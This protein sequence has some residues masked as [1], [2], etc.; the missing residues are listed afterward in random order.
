MILLK[1]KNAGRGFT[2]AEVMIVV[3]IVAILATVAVILIRPGDISYIEYNR[4]A[5]AIA[6]AVQNRLTDIRNTGDMSALRG[7]GVSAVASGTPSTGAGTSAEDAGGLRCVFSHKSVGTSIT[8]NG[9]MSYI[10]PFGA[11]EHKLT[12]SYY[13]VCYESDTGMVRFVLYSE[14]YF[15]D[16]TFASIEKYIGSFGEGDTAAVAAEAARKADNIG[17]YEG[18]VDSQ[19]V[20]FA[21]LPTPQLTVTNYEELTLNIFLPEVKQLKGKNIGFIVSL[22]DKNG[23]AYKGS[24]GKQKLTFADAAIYSTIDFGNG[25]V[26]PRYVKQKVTTGANYKMILDTVRSCTATDLSKSLTID[27]NGSPTPTDQLPKGIFEDWANR[28]KAFKK[29]F[30]LGENTNI[31]VTVYC[32]DDAGA[33]DPTF[34]PRSA[35]I[36][37]NGWFNDC[38]DDTHSDGRVTG[39]VDIACGRH[40]QNL[41]K[42]SVMRENLIKYLPTVEDSNDDGIFEYGKY[43]RGMADVYT[44][45]SS[46]AS[47]EVKYEDVTEKYVLRDDVFE[48]T[49]AQQ[50]NAIDFNTAGWKED[51]K[52]I[53]FT[54]INLPYGFYY[55]GNYLTISHLYVF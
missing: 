22:A 27:E 3:A 45:G 21:N 55:Y 19:E 38:K 42:I 10:L 44:D 53:P 8:S 20:A 12:Q 47:P 7:L 49:E 16:N 15:G 5:E 41:G 31:T 33:I 30:K 48:I 6:T 24:E 40:L 23:D 26:D 28:T 13:V 11:I 29:Y 54:P 39:I 37:F 50:V 9:E 14:K 36:T 1:R 25:T 46:N 43:D 18:E 2:L 35:T 52:P 4:D 34:L 32:L 51:G 17:Y